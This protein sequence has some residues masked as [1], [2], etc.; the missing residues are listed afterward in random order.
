MEHMNVNVRIG[1]QLKEHLLSVTGEHGT[2]DNTSEYI[3]DLIRRDQDA[4]AQEAVDWLYA[5]L[6]PAIEADASEY[7]SVTAEDVI[8]RN[9]EWKKAQERMANE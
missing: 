3:R 8:R 7:V 1:G 4:Q 2:Y 5:H 6:K 9:Q